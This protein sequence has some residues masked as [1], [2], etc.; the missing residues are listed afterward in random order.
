M[1]RA[2]VVAIATANRIN[3][4]ISSSSLISYCYAKPCSV[5]S[6]HGLTYGNCIG[7]LSTDDGYSLQL[8]SRSAQAIVYLERHVAL[9]NKHWFVISAY[10][11]PPQKASF[12]SLVKFLKEQT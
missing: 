2:I 8:G 5:V 4:I 7:K 1:R 10:Y 11:F 6:A 12:L 9:P 3:A